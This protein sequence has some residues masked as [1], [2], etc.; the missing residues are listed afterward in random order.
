MHSPRRFTLLDESGLRG[1]GLRQR[2]RIPHHQ[3]ANL[4]ENQAGLL[5][6]S[7]AEL[8]DSLEERLDFQFNFHK[9]GF[10][11]TSSEFY[12]L[13]GAIMLC[14]ALVL[15]ICGFKF[16]SARFQCW[17]T[18]PLLLITSFFALKHWYNWEINP[19]KFVCIECKTKQIYVK[20]HRGGRT[21]YSEAWDV[22]NCIECKTEFSSRRNTKK[23]PLPDPL[24]D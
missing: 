4:L 10:S 19:P 18:A 21:E 1:V 17:G 8:V 23:K 6:R 13:Y 24:W 12:G 15:L 14:W 5:A 7:G 22:V 9:V 2:H 11:M 20:K 16:K 3:L